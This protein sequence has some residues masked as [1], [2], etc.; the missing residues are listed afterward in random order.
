MYA[1]VWVQMKRLLQKGHFG[2]ML[3]GARSPVPHDLV[4]VFSLNFLLC[5]LKNN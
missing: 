3:G 5:Y 2:V 1:Q 4:W